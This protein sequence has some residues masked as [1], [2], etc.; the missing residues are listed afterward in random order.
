MP[1]ISIRQIFLQNIA[2]IWMKNGTKTILYLPLP[3]I[4]HFYDQTV[5]SL[6]KLPQG[7]EELYFFREVSPVIYNLPDNG[8]RV[9]TTR[10]FGIDSLTAQKTKATRCTNEWYEALVF[11][12][13]PIFTAFNNSARWWNGSSV[14][15]NKGHRLSSNGK[16]IIPPSLIRFKFPFG[17]YYH[18]SVSLT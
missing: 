12:D 13:V 15:H 6:A 14:Y 7:S 11:I 4:Y 16:K 2:P 3:D 8:G 17:E 1:R 18:F 9:I 5:R 10:R